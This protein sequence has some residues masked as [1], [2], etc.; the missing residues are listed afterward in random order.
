MDA[1][2]DALAAFDAVGQTAQTVRD[3]RELVIATTPTNGLLLTEALSELVGAKPV[4]TSACAGPM[5]PTTCSARSSEEAE[6]GFS[7]L[8]P[9]LGDRQLTV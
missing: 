7:E 9:L 8:T 1:A 3:K 6:I 2:R 5:T 4:S